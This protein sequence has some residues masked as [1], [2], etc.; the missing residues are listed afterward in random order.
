MET[1]TS[2]I[3]KEPLAKL[4]E[5]G[6][7]SILNYNLP[8]STSYEVVSFLRLDISRS[9]F[10][11]SEQS[12]PAG[13]YWEELGTQVEPGKIKSERG[14]RPGPAIHLER[15]GVFELDRAPGPEHQPQL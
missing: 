14:H 1:K 12:A 4:D 3:P 15:Q 6:S 13:D 2:C 5:N 7:A 11:K 8:Q 9:K 10:K